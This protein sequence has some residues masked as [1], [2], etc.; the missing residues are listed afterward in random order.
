MRIAFDINHPADVHTFK[1][2]IQYLKQQGQTVLVTARHS[3]CS[4]ELLVENQI[5]FVLRPSGRGLFN[6]LAKVPL[7]LKFL[8]RAYRF[9]K[10]DLLIGGPG[11]LYVAQLGQMIHKPAIVFDDTEH[12]VIQNWLTFPFATTVWTPQCYLLNLGKKQVRFNGSKEL[13]YL[14]PNYYQF[15]RQAF[16]HLFWRQL[17][18]EGKFPL[19]EQLQLREKPVLL[20]RM[21][22]WRASHDLFREGIIHLQQIV[23]VLQKLGTI[24]LSTGGECPPEFETIRPQLSANRLHD[25]I[26]YADVV[27][28]EGATTAAEAA[29]LGTPAIYCNLF[30]L[31]YIEEYEKYGLITPAKTATAVIRSVETFLQQSDLK[32][33]YQARREK[34]LQEKEDVTRWMINYLKQH[35]F[36]KN[37]P[38]FSRRQVCQ[39]AKLDPFHA[40]AGGIENYVGTISGQL[41][42][43]NYQV[44]FIG[45]DELP[46]NGSIEIPLQLRD[47]ASLVQKF[48]CDGFQAVFRNHQPAFSTNV[49]FLY[50]LCL[51]APWLKLS[52]QFVLHFHRPDFVLPFLA[53]PNPKICTI[54]GNPRQLIKATKS[55]GITLTY[56]LFEKLLLRFFK[57]LIFVSHSAMKQYQNLFPALIDNMQVIPP[58]IPPHFQRVSADQR[59]QWREKNGWTEADQILLFVGRLE[60]EKQVSLIIERIDKLTKEEPS[61]KSTHLVIVGEGSLKTQLEK[62]LKRLANPNIRMPGFIPSSQLPLIYSSVDATLLFS[63][64]EGLPGV[65]LESL[66]CGT[67]VIANPVGDLPLLIR[68]GYNGSLLANSYDLNKITHVL[69]Y[70]KEMAG[71]CQES[72]KPYQVDQ[73]IQ[74]LIEVYEKAFG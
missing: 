45:V 9:F 46:A 4:A 13:A 26:A 37:G 31:G 23:P 11:N 3:L 69:R 48:E 66:A 27:V 28:S 41:K 2:L 67:P 12:T 70:S 63:V 39:V 7:I 36:L 34:M 44:Q 8:L 15:D 52:P 30:R 72:V 60:L 54:H 74:A 65:A 16:E 68:D 5:D 17:Q 57:C 20:L 64:T 14:H 59:K 19:L 73:I 50:H 38:G 71:H 58:P 55:F 42:A 22:G 56:T 40:R 53:F 29:V 61:F 62:Q 35:Y 47:K 51:K 21:V 24:I 32:Q 43:L 10:P 33:R 25:L 49:Q 1:Y 18:A 6:R